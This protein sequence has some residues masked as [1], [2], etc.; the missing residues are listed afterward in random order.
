MDEAFE[1]W[2][3]NFWQSNDQPEVLNLA[4]KEVAKAGWDARKAKLEGALKEIIQR[5][6]D[7]YNACDYYYTEE[8]HA[9][10]DGE[11]VAYATCRE[12]AE[13]GLKS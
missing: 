3:A 8:E 1:A 9:R 6:I 12:I 11:S 5:D 2:W 4:W 7:F 13:E 10:A